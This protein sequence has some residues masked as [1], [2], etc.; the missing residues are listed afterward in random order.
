MN[1]RDV[2]LGF[3]PTF[4]A[5]GRLGSFAAAA[6]ELHLTPSAVSQQIRALEGALEVALFQRTGRAAL[7]TSAGERYLREVRHVLQSL[8]TA[9]SRLRRRGRE[10]V[11]R[12]S[13]VAL[14][15]YEFILPRLRDFQAA[16]PGIQLGVETSNDVIDFD[17]TDCDAALRVGSGWD[18]G[19]CEHRLGGA[20]VAPVCAPALAA[21]IHGLADLNEYPLLD[22][23]P[24]AVRS[25]QELMHAEG[26]PTRT[27]VHDWHFESCYDTLRAAE[28]R[29]GVALA[30]FPVATPWVSD[31]RLAVPLSVRLPLPGQ[32]YFV[33][34]R[35][36]E[37]F[38]F[39]DIA[40]WFATQ[41][42]ALPGLPP[43]RQ[44]LG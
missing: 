16:F 23:V 39:S 12:I 5:A 33:H 42:Q 19:L 4:E 2:P 40:A 24:G 25:L 38:P 15:A 37:R 31:G 28:H 32:V 27:V 30:V 8:S 18:D 41:Y 7:L 10:A 11:L 43:G 6:A 21:Q 17:V 20:E 44:V 35:G 36:D 14:A 26:L 3:L 29:L 9:S 13:T 34:R 22:S 1:I